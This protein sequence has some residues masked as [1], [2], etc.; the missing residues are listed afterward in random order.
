[1]EGGMGRSIMSS[2]GRTGQLPG[3]LQFLWELAVIHYPHSVRDLSWHKK[4]LSD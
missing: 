1:M 4:Q 2:L 3:L